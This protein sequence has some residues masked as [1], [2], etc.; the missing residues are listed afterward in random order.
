MG[1]LIK[2]TPDL[3]VSVVEWPEGAGYQFL[4]EQI[5]GHIEHVRPVRLYEW[6]K[7]RNLPEH[8]CMLVDEE[9]LLKDLPFNPL[10]SY[11]YKTDQHGCPI[12]GP[13]LIV[14]ET[15]DD[16]VPIAAMDFG[17]LLMLLK[18]IIGSLGGGNYVSR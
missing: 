17:E 18:L 16:F 7:K 12:A 14:Q 8:Y 2:I 15:E 11:L 3:E 4:Q 1:K 9:G 5:G 10:G 13:I 6:L